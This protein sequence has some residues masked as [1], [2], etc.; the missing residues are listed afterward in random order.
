[1]FARSARHE[2]EVLDAAIIRRILPK[3]ESLA[4]TPVPTALAS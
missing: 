2:L 3:V 4:D 1:V